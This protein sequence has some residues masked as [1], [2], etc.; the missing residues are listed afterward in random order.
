MAGSGLEKEATNFL[1][2]RFLR[3]VYHSFGGE[4]TKTTQQQQKT[5]FKEPN[6]LYQKEAKGADRQ[7][8]K[9]PK[10]DEHI[11]YEKMGMGGKCT[12]PIYTLQFP[13]GPSCTW[14]DTSFSVLKR[15][16]NYWASTGS[17]S[18]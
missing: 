14:T 5:G 3:E 2:L 10:K 4:K 7:R 1:L 11:P 6:W 9:P 12:A 16:F 8:L 18:K 17:L 15:W 13:W